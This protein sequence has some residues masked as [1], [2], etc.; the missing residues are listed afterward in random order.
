MSLKGFNWALK[1]LE[2][3]RTSKIIILTKGLI[4]NDR[5]YTLSEYA[6]KKLNLPQS[7]FVQIA[8]PCI[9]SDLL[10]GQSPI[11]IIVA[12]TQ[13]LEISQ[14]LSHGNVNAI[15]SQNI[16]SI[17]LA[18]ALKNIYAIAVNATPNYTTQA[19]LFSDILNELE[20]IAHLFNSETDQSF[21]L[22]TSGDLWVTSH[23][24]RNG[25]FGKL[26]SQNL[27]KQ[28]ALDKMK[29]QTIEGIELA[30][31]L[32]DLWMSNTSLSQIPIITHWISYLNS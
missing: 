30:N 16:T 11:K 21:Q 7:S 25:M 20:D 6:Q 1:C 17:S 31:S 32:H 14:T 24:G 9:A 15:P 10:N 3:I 27:T 19:A 29:D 8:G 13:S 5:I 4:A 28:Q 12:G 18:S 26:L 23:S 22:A 2:N